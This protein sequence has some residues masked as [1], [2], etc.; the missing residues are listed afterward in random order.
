VFKELAV[1]AAGSSQLKKKSACEDLA[2]DLKT[3]C[4]L[5][6]SDTRSVRFSET[7]K[8]PVLQILCHETDS[9]DH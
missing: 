7:F 2:F 1:R 5:Q 9:G 3:F 8:V 6:C 4:V